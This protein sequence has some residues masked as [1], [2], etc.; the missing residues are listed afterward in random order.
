MLPDNQV[1]V[2]ICV[3]GMNDAR[4]LK[5]I[6]RTLHTFD[7]SLPDLSSDHR[8]VF[9]PMHGG[10]LRDVVN[11]HLVIISCMKER[12]V[13]VLSGVLSRHIRKAAENIIRKPNWTV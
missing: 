5:H 10:N 4:F 11:Q 2:L 3:E 9:I 7:G 12:D 1:R 13:E 6:S 8:F